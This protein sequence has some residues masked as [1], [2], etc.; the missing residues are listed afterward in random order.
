[1]FHE[2]FVY[3][4]YEENPDYEHVKQQFMNLQAAQRTIHKKADDIPA[5]APFSHAKIQKSLGELKQGKNLINF[6]S[7]EHRN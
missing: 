2:L 6:L 1:M 3:Q 5:V 7:L 4:E